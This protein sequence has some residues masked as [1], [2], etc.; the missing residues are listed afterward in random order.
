MRRVQEWEVASE[1]QWQ[2]FDE[3]ERQ[4]AIHD[5][6]L[7][8]ITDGTQLNALDTEWNLW[9]SN[10]LARAFRNLPQALAGEK[11]GIDAVLQAVLN[12]RNRC[13]DDAVSVLEDK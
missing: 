13:Y 12:M 10:D 11:H 2:Q 3:Q 9:I 6:A 5:K 8:T 7:D 1:A 4:R